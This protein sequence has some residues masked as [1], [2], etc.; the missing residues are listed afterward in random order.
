MRILFAQLHSFGDIIRIFPTV[1]GIRRRY[2]DAFLVA[3]CTSAM[4]E[5][6]AQ[7]EALD[8]VLPQ[9][10]LTPP[11]NA[12]GGTRIVDLSVLADAVAEARDLAFDRYIDFHGI[13]Q[14][15]AFGAMAG[16][17]E[18][19]GLAA[20]CCRDG[21]HLFY[22]SHYNPGAAGHDW[23]TMNRMTR[24]LELARAVMPGL[25]PAVPTLPQ[26]DEIIVSPGTSGL[27]DYKRWPADRYAALVRRI[28]E[29]RPHARV[30][31]ACGPD[32]HEAAT[33][34][35]AQ[36]A[37]ARCRLV[38]LDDFA[39]VFRLVS[40]ARC[41]I[42]GDT[43]YAHAATVQGVPTFMVLGPTGTV[44]APWRHVVGATAERTDLSCRPC[45]LWSRACPHG[46]RC[47][48]ELGTE[49]VAQRLAAFLASLPQ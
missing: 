23:Y 34:V 27:G 28:L 12:R 24:H 10:R 20:G 49:E 44:S 21:S 3:T 26:R 43:A 14:S 33:A 25:A 18:R 8:R 39:E 1:R 40:G 47:M 5:V 38:H 42:G 13:F 37:S 2:P 6:M 30:A 36:C 17:A 9:P 22:T 16:I 46:I 41:F 31:I 45:D 32:D 4:A 19:H 48:S 11:Q 29:D 35:M 15:A 7:C